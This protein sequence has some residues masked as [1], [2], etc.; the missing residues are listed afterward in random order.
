MANGGSTGRLNK[1]ISSGVAPP[2][3][4]S[5][6]SGSVES[7]QLMVFLIWYDKRSDP[8]VCARGQL[9]SLVSPLC[10]ALSQQLLQV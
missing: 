9:N 4:H 5:S 8:M 7:I 3:V 2:L 10:L 1:E 6:D